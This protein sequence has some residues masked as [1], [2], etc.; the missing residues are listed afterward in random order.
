MVLILN[1]LLVCVY[2]QIFTA[3]PPLAMGLFDRICS[4]ESMM[5]FPALYK[6]SQNAEL[7]N[8]KVHKWMINLDHVRAWN[9]MYLDVHDKRTGDSENWC[10]FVG[11][12]DV[13]L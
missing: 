9:V 1:N 6:S 13:D 5:K 12:L 8:A 3:A 7:F 11:I 4:S 10:C 2:L